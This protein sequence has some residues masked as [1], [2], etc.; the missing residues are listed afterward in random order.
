MQPVNPQLTRRRF[1]KGVIASG[2]VA[3]TTS[4]WYAASGQSR[5]AG[6]VERMLRLNVNG[7]E[8]TVDVAPQETLA[9]TL[10]YKL[11]L[12]GTKLGCNRG[13]C[14][15]CTVLVDDIPTYACSVLTHSM[16]DGRIETVEGLEAPDGTLHPVQ[17]GF[18]EA[19]SP[20]CGYCTPG[21]V[22]AAVGLLRANP[23]PTREQV[24]E[25][26]AGNLCRCG[27]YDS[28]LDGVMRAVELG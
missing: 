2:A 19:L 26:L 4:L 8:R 10:R 12:T 22:M 6:A 5:P 23:N 17:Q 7:Q 24:R 14:G 1:I 27:S 21:Q 20:Q 11:G 15:A 9:S 18:V 16:K 25:G 13:E 3:G 28:Y